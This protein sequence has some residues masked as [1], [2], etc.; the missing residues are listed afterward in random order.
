[1]HFTADTEFRDLLERVRALASHHLPHGDLKTVLQR[2][3][4]AYERELLKKRFAV[5][6]K[7]R[8]SGVARLT[9]ESMSEV[10]SRSSLKPSLRA[11][12]A[13]KR[14]RASKMSR[15]VPAAVL[16]E[17]YERDGGQCAFVSKGGRRCGARHFLQVD[18][19]IPFAWGG[20]AETE[21]LRLLCRAH[22]LLHARRCFG[23]A[24]MR[25][26]VSRARPDRGVRPGA[27]EM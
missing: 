5:G 9:T 23:S 13:L 26:A 7:P 3:L 15:A 21:T 16:R 14:L 27:G 1:M 6:A 19:V 17:L 20:G 2:G 24:F 18:H 11:F 10:A 4:E 25:A 8:A 12:R 22:N